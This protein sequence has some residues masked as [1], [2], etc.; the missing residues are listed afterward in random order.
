VEFLLEQGA[1]HRSTD[2]QGDTPLILACLRK[3]TGVVRRLLQETT[4]A[5]VNHLNHQ[6]RSALYY[7]IAT[8]NMDLMSLLQLH[9]ASV[10]PLF[11]TGSIW[12]SG[13]PNRV[14]LGILR[15]LVDSFGAD[16]NEMTRRG[17]TALYLLTRTFGYTTE[18]ISFLLSR[19]ANPWLT[20][21]NGELPLWTAQTVAIRRL[22]DNAMHEHQRFQ[23]LEKVRAWHGMYQHMERVAYHAKTRD[24]KRIKCIPVAPRVLKERLAAGQKLPTYALKQYPSRMHGVLVHLIERANDDVFREL[25]DMMKVSWDS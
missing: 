14:P 1:C 21:P 4:P 5:D 3:E 23:M 18:A 15:C 6:G 22:L 2:E 17:K 24:S 10:H 11:A 12:T 7:A 8:R 25:F 9:G 20:P 16:V 19:G 13:Y